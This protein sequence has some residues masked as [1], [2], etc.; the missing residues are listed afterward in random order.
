[1]TVLKICLFTSYRF[2]NLQ[3][4]PETSLHHIRK[5]GPLDQ[6]WSHYS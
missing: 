6:G 2:V 4:Y 5:K 3:K 1:M